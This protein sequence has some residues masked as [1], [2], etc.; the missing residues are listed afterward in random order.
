[1]QSGQLVL[2]VGEKVIIETV[3]IDVIHDF[4]VPQW[5]YKMDAVP[6]NQGS[7]SREYVTPTKVGSYHPECAELCGPGHAQMTLTAAPVRVVP[8][9]EFASYISKLKKQSN[10]QPPGAKVF[11]SEGCGGCHAYKPANAQGKVGPDLDNVAADAQAAGK[12]VS[13]YVRE[14]IV[15]PNVVIAKNCPTGPCQPNVMPGDYGDKIQNKDLEDLISFVSGG[16]P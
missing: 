7:N 13:Q 3:S 10:K 11:A 1:M 12:T 6:G 16:K 5:R 9:S 4:F 8:K 14:S 15:Q 2:P